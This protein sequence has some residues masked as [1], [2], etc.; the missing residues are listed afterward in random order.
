[1]GTNEKGE[2]LIKIDPDLPNTSI[3]NSNL[4]FRD[5]NGNIFG[6]VE[7]KSKSILFNHFTIGKSL[8]VPFR[9]WNISSDSD[10]IMEKMI[11]IVNISHNSNFEHGL[12]VVLSNGGLN[13]SV[14]RIIIA[15]SDNLSEPFG[16]NLWV[17]EKQ[18]LMKDKDWVEFI[19]VNDGL[20]YIGGSL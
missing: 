1:M 19:Q 17:F 11:N 13:G 18:F 20:I 3:I 6:K 16:I 15:V 8:S 7:E 12:T 14:Y 10:L 4:F 5:N 9:I 2:P